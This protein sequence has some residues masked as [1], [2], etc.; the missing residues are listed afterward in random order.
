MDIATKKGLGN[1]QDSIQQAS[2]T[3]EKDDLH[4]AS[5][6]SSLSSPLQEMETTPVDIINNDMALWAQDDP[7]SHEI[8]NFDEDFRLDMGHQSPSSDWDPFL[9]EFPVPSFA[10]E[11]LELV[12]TDAMTG[13][14]SP[15]TPS[16][17]FPVMKDGASDL[18]SS[19]VFQRPS[20]L[21][22]PRLLQQLHPHSPSSKSV[23]RP[24]L[25]LR[26]ANSA[27]DCICLQQLTSNLFSLNNQNVSFHHMDIDTFLVMYQESMKNCEV[28]NDCRSACVLRR[29]FAVLLMMNVEHLAKLQLDLVVRM[30]SAKDGLSSEARLLRPHGHTQS[31]RSGRSGR[32]DSSRAVQPS[33]PPTSRQPISIGKYAVEDV[34]EK[35]MIVAQL[36]AARIEHLNSFIKTS[37]ARL[38]QAGLDDCCRG[39]DTVRVKLGKALRRL[40]VS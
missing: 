27:E 13:L 15:S 18:V 21:Y 24:D 5:S 25:A 32:L 26:M 1:A 19:D 8:A 37:R 16:W 31:I 20:D 36:L 35:E 2:E 30:T 39:L 34:L 6:A 12:D 4:S 38:M 22:D 33:S 23:S 28:V 7:L 17:S 14:T 10:D 3:T 9:T 11:E 40:G 29:E